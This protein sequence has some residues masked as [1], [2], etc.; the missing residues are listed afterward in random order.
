[1]D[2]LYPKIEPNR[3]HYLDV[4]DGH[5]IYVEECG[6]P[7][8]IPV[9][10]V[11]G[12]PGMGCSPDHR[13]FFNPDRYRII[14]FDQRGCGR[15]KPFASLEANTTAHLIADM[16][17]IREE[18]EVESWMLFGGSW[19]STLSLA[20]AEAHPERV[21]AMILRGI[22]LCRDRDLRWFLQDGADRIFPDHWA[23]FIKPVPPEERHDLIAAYYRLLTAEDETTRQEAAKAWSLWEGRCATLLPDESIREK[24]GDPE[25]ALSLARIEC[26]YF[27]NRIFLEPEQL[28][29]QAARLRGIPGVIVH[30]RYDVVCPVDQAF[31]LQKVWPDADLQVIPDAGHAVSEPGI[32]DALVTATDDYAE[33]LEGV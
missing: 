11:H 12:G 8:G 9:L 2:R 16:E 19:G 24:F 6:N 1:M 25:V 5:Q 32:S 21:R 15:S 33:R 26:H 31:A 4:G 28:L 29:K 3:Q 23:D 14:L 20:Y 27:E 22:F 13:R 17:A 30:G 18:A 7:D 10:F